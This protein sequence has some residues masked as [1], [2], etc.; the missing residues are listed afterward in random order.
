MTNSPPWRIILLDE[1]DSTNRLM[2]E[3]YSS[4]SLERLVVVAD[5]QSAGRGRRDRSFADIPRTSLMCSV[6]VCLPTSETLGLLPLAV[7]NSVMASTL[8][9]GAHGA[10]LK[11]PN[12]L[13]A[14]GVKLGG[15]LV[16]GVFTD[17]GYQGALGLGVNLT[18]APHLED[19]RPL[20][21][22][23]DLIGSAAAADFF[24][25]REAFLEAFLSDLDQQLGCLR[26]G[27]AEAVL[28]T[29]RGWCATINQ[30]VRIHY[31]DHETVGVAKDVDELGRL[32]VMTA[33]EEKIVGVGEVVHLGTLGV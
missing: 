22:L 4:I 25:L 32:I 1:V 19:E 11:W 33:D 8:A 26:E 16:D 12:D 31:R 23:A 27:R 5:H 6:L 20:G 7:G 24:A 21:C 28:G 9:L 30:R 13:E 2:T 17:H 3:C 15:I 18:A 10:C 29:Y 14:N